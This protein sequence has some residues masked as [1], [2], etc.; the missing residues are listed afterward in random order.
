MNIEEFMLGYKAAWEQRDP[1]MFAALFLPD[2]KYHNT[3][4]QVQRGTEQLV[5]YWKRVQLQED[6][7]VTFEVLAAAATS[8]IARWRTTY[9]VA[10]EELF[11]IWA[12][13]TG[14]SLVARKPGDPLPR[15]VLDGV[16]QATFSANR[17]SVARIWWH[18]LPQP[19]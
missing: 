14:T 6:V 9:Q 19:A 8:G 7:T 5:A 10:S 17:C 1:A 3:P 13:S 11:Q 4:F 18:S 16:L 2:G 15:M 12:K